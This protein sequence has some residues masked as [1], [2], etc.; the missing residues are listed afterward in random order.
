MLISDIFSAYE[1]YANLGTVHSDEQK[2]KFKATFSRKHARVHFLGVWYVYFQHL[3][4]VDVSLS[5]YSGTLLLLSVSTA[6]HLP[7]WLAIIIMFALFAMPWPWMKLVLHSCTFLS[8][9]GFYLLTHYTLNLTRYISRKFGLQERILRC[10]Y[11]VILVPFSFASS[12]L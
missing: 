6:A 5:E 7:S 10:K 9:T 3:E 2:A 8:P 1:L 11:G 4:N 12:D